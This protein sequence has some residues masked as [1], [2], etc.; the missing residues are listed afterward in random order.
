[1]GIEHLTPTNGTIELSIE[2][3]WPCNLVQA[4]AGLRPVLFESPP[5]QPAGA[6][7]W[8]QGMLTTVAGGQESN[9]IQINPII[10]DYF[11]PRVHSVILKKMSK[12][13]AAT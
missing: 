12:T 9:Q 4:P 7:A 3:S 10:S 8:L 1:M 2:P 5:Q 13:M 6:R 11:L